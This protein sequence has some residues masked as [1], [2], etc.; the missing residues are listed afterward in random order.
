MVTRKIQQSL[1][2]AFPFIRARTGEEIKL[3]QLEGI[4]RLRAESNLEGLEPRIQ[5]HISR[6]VEIKEG[7]VQELSDLT[8]RE[9]QVASFD[10]D[11]VAWN[12]LPESE[13]ALWILALKK[14]AESAINYWQGLVV[15][16]SK[17]GANQYERALRFVADNP[18]THSEQYEHSLTK[19]ALEQIRSRMSG[20][21]S[22]ILPPLESNVDFWERILRRIHVVMEATFAD[23]CELDLASQ[24]RTWQQ[25]KHAIP[26]GD[27][28]SDSYSELDRLLGILCP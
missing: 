4:D 17:R 19:V 10:S 5:R 21:E 22:H 8:Q 12:S 24:L 23:S 11:R 20:L 3:R 16:P 25:L 13:R 15:K 26:A 1:S 18:P 28:G 14:E 7:F 9:R 2:R 27:G 6:A